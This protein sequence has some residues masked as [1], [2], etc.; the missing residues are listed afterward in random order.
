MAKV[1]LFAINLYL[2]LVMFPLF[3]LLF[4]TFRTHI[5]GG[6]YSGTNSALV[7]AAAPALFFELLLQ[8]LG[9]MWTFTEERQ[10]RLTEFVMKI[11]CL[12]HF[13]DEVTNILT[14]RE[15]H[16]KSVRENDN[17]V[18]Q[19]ANLHMTEARLPCPGKSL[20]IF[21]IGN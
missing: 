5:R 17:T 14:T 6:R 15:P 9:R 7:A 12:L 10:L 18:T 3:A 1:T 4:R 20:H 8:S 19:S 11:S 16:V 13:Y 21:E 2:I